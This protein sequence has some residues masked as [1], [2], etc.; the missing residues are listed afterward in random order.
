M[1]IQHHIVRALRE[2]LGLT[3]AAFGEPL[4][5]SAVRVCQIEKGSGIAAATALRI[6]DEYGRGMAGA[7]ISLEDLLRNASESAA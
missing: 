5:L 4:G 6:H 3:Q 7:G 1:A 2:H